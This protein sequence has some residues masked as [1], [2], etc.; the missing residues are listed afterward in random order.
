MSYILHHTLSF[1]GVLLYEAC[2]VDMI[3]STGNPRRYFS[4]VLVRVDDDG[5]L[6][7]LSCFSREEKILKLC[8]DKWGHVVLECRFLNRSSQVPCMLLRDLVLILELVAVKLMKS[9]SACICCSSL[10]YEWEGYAGA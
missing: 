10:S 1:I 2:T 8:I 5:F 4:I 7:I 6:V 9:N 3:S